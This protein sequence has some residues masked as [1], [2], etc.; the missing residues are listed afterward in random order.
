MIKFLL[1]LPFCIINYYSIV[2]SF[3]H[4]ILPDLTEKHERCFIRNKNC[5][6]F[7]STWVQVLF[8]WVVGPCCYVLDL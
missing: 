3:L 1:P 8:F 5:L 4:M 6:L 2:M 7:A